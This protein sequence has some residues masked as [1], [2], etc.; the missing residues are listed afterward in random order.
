MP[1]GSDIDALRRALA[2]AE[3]E[4]IDAREKATEAEARAANAVAKVSDAKAQIAALKLMIEKLTVALFTASVRSASGSFST[5]WSSSSTSL[6]R[7]PPRTSWR[8]NAKRYKH[9]SSFS[10][11]VTI[12]HHVEII[13]SAIA[14]VPLTRRGAGGLE[15]SARLYVGG[16]QSP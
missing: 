1:D 2:A 7:A 13:D 4:A 12:G 5:S 15:T 8:P 3:A 14:G 16:D 9:C 11:S 10:T 6:R